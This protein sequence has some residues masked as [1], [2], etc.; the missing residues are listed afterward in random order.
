NQQ[1]AEKKIR[2]KRL[3]RVLTLHLKRFKYVE[4]LENFS[5]LS[6]RVVFPLELRTPNM[7]DA[8]GEADADGRLYRQASL[9]FFF[10]LFAVVVHIGRGPN[11]GHYVA[12][13]K[14]GGRWLLFDDEIVELVNEQ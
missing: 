13:V 9:L 11:H 8:A 1:E 2:L 5:K 4:S 12:V 6:H 3:P 14:S 7:T 10:L